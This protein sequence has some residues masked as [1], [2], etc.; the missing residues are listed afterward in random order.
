MKEVC[1]CETLA[2]IYQTSGCNIPNGHDFYFERVV[3][4]SQMCCWR[5]PPSRIISNIE[6]DITPPR[7]VWTLLY[8]DAVSHPERTEYSG[9]FVWQYK[10]KLF[11]FEVTKAYSGVGS[12]VLLIPNLNSLHRSPFTPIKNSRYA[13]TPP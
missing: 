12:V 3:M 1:C 11:P 6:G 13:L 9:V 8:I 5:F 10:V 7:N 4:F 2:P